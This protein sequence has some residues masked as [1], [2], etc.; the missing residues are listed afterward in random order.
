MESQQE[1]KG[2]CPYL[3]ESPDE[4]GAAPLGGGAWSWLALGSV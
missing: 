4:I 2:V 1:S 3:A